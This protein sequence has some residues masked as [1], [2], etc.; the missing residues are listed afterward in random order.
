MLKSLFS[1]QINYPTYLNIFIEWN[2]G[3]V[4]VFLKILNPMV[5]RLFGFLKCWN[6]LL[7]KP[8]LLTPKMHSHL[9]LLYYIHLFSIKNLIIFR[10][11]AYFYTN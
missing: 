6:T 11:Y 9:N 4:F 7:I 8:N 5:D 10:K 3:T 1:V 2:K